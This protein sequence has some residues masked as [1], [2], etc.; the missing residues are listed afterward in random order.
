MAVNRIKSYKKIFI[1]GVVSN[2]LTMYWIVPTFKYAGESLTLGVLSLIIL[3]SYISIYWVL[4]RILTNDLRE[5]F[6]YVIFSSIVWVMM[7]II[8]S[9]AFSGLPWCLLGLS[10]WKNIAILKIAKSFGVYGVSFFIFFFGSLI[11]LLVIKKKLLY[12]ILLY[13]IIISTN[14]LKPKPE[15]GSIKVAILQGSIDQ[16][17]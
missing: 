9:Y 16:Y 3:S 7:E 10:Q 14:F 1:A 8:R 12:A 17:K 4:W 2:I 13:L 5:N 6:Y 11:Y 15:T